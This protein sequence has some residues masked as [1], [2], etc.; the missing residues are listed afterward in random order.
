MSKYEDADMAF[1]QDLKDTSAYELARMAGC[2][3]P[4]SRTSAGAEFLGEIRDAVVERWEAGRFDWDSSNSDGDL[5][6]EC[7]AEGIIPDG[8]H[9]VALLAVDLGAYRE[10]SEHTMNGQWSGTIDEILRDAIAQVG[11]RATVACVTQAREDFTAK[12]TCSLCG[13][14]GSP[15][16]CFPGVCSGSDDEV[17]AYQA[18]LADELAQVQADAV[19][20]QQ[21]PQAVFDAM[22]AQ[23]GAQGPQQPSETQAWLARAA[24]VNAEEFGPRM[25]VSHRLTLGF[26]GALTLVAVVALVVGVWL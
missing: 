21:V 11:Y 26:L 5:I 18:Q 17:E 7:E 14:S 20:A 23:D 9:D 16:L 15:H 8:Y 22:S 19:M 3:S 25:S 6:G 10:S 4:A 13:D 2:E 24:Q 1:L 12:F